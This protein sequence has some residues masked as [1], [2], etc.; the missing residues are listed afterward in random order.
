MPLLKDNLTNGKSQTRKQFKTT[1]IYIY[2]Y[3]AP[4]N[5]NCVLNI[6]FGSL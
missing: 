3:R 1:Y 5:N 2:T 4:V 6:L